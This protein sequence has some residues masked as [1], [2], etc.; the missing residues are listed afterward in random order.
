M[1]EVP[2]R[3]AAPPQPI[4]AVV[5]PAA[6]QPMREVVQPFV[7]PEPEETPAA[8]KPM[9]TLEE[10][11]ADL[12]RLRASA[13]ERHAQAMVPVRRDVAFAPT[14]FMDFAKPE[15]PPSEVSESSFEA[16]AYLDFTTLKPRESS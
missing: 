12:A 2:A 10:V 8:I 16:T 7:Q 11:R 1:V 9:R 13:K 3:V 14:D 15:A 6:P 4:R 5:Q